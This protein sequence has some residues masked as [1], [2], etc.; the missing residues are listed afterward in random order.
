MQIQY[1]SGNVYGSE[2]NRIMHSSS[3]R[4]NPE[5]PL[6]S[7]LW[8]NNVGCLKNRVERSAIIL[9]LL[10]GDEI[11][12]KVRN[13]RPHTSHSSHSCPDSIGGL[14]GS[15]FILASFA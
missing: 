4:S 15:A 14:R 11:S 9:E 2:A 10:P 1:V 8:V 13:Y 12:V 7:F 6:S 3:P 5:P